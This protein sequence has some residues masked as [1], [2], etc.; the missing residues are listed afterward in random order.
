MRLL[1]FSLLVLVSVTYYLVFF[2]NDY[3]FSSLAYTDHVNWIYLPSGFT[4]GFVLVLEEIGVLGILLPSLL[5]NLQ[6]DPNETTVAIVVTSLITAI[7]PLIART[8]CVKWLGL[9]EDLSELNYKK[10]TECSLIFAL[11]SSACLQLWFHFKNLDEI[12]LED[13]LAMFVGDVF[14]SLIVL[15]F[16]AY[17]IKIYRYF[18]ARRL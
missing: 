7:T 12:F 13:F 16:G 2:F 5:I 17:A 4:L 15:F 1:N 18:Q 14:G 3:L 11:I 8:I 9:D 10:I 6:L